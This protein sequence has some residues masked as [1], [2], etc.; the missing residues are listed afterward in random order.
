MITLAGYRIGTL[1]HE[2]NSTRLYDAV[3]TA[4][5]RPVLI[6]LLRPEQLT[7]ENR[8]AIRREKELT[9]RLDLEGVLR[10]LALET[11]DSGAALVL[12]HYGGLPLSHLSGRGTMKLEAVLAIARNVVDI[13]GGLHQRRIFHGN[14]SPESILVEPGTHKVKLTDLCLHPLFL[15]GQDADFC[16]SLFY[17]SPEQT[18]RMNR[19]VDFRTDFYSL[20]V[21]LYELLTGEVPFRSSD[22]LQLIHSHIA[23]EPKDPVAVNSTL[24]RPIADIVLKLLA[25]NAKDRYQSSYGLQKDLETCLSGL[26]A[27]GRI[28]DFTLAAADASPELTIPSRLYGRE[29][30]TSQLRAACERARLGSNELL[31][32]A[33][34]AGVGKTALIN[35]VRETVLE[36]GGLFLS[37]KYDQLKKNVPYSSII[38]A[39]KQ[40]IGRI[41]GENEDVLRRW[42]EK[43]LDAVSTNGQLIIDVIPDVKLIIGEQ[44]RVAPA[45]PAESLNRFNRVVQKFV[46]VFARPEHPLV[47]FLD[48]L[49]W[50]DPASLNLIR[51]LLTDSGLKHL[52][53]IGAFRS[54]EV[55]P[56]HPMQQLLD[57]NAG[58]GSVSRI[59]LE[60]LTEDQT[61]A[62]I[63]DTL[64]CPPDRSAPLARIVQYKTGGNPFFVNQM[65]ILLHQEKLLAYDPEGGWRWDIEEIS[66]RDVAEDVVELLVGKIGRLAPGTRE[67]LTLASC[68]GNRF[69]LAT[70]AIV[71]NRSED[72]ILQELI[73]ALDE[74]MV[75]AAEDRFLFFHDRIQEAAYSLLSADEKATVH[76]RIG[77]LI[78]ASTAAEHLQARVFYI[79]DQLNAGSICMADPSERLRLAELNF[80][81]GRK[82]KKSTAYASAEKYL[83]EGIALLPADVWQKRYDLAI[84][85]HKE[86]A[87]CASL[88]GDMERADLLFS[89]IELNASTDLDRAWP[90]AVRVPLYQGRGMPREAFRFGVNALRILGYDMPENP[91]K[92]DLAAELLKTLWH[93]KLYPARHF[94]DLPVLTDPKRNAIMDIFA[95]MAASAYF[96]SRDLL[97]LIMLKTFSFS[98]RYGNAPSSPAAYGLYGM[99]LGSILGNYERGHD[100]G[101]MGLALADKFNDPVSRAMADFTHA[102]FIAHWKEPLAKCLTL[103]VQGYTA[104]LESGNI[105]YAGY[106]AG[107]HTAFMTFKGD[108]LDDL[109]EQCRTYLEVLKK[110]GGEDMILGI[111]T[112]LSSAEELA[113][114]PAGTRIDDDQLIRTLTEGKKF[115]ALCLHYTFRLPV[116][117]LFGRYK[118]GEQFADDLDRKST[119]ILGLYHSAS[120]TFYQALI[121]AARCDGVERTRQKTY[122]RVLARN[123]KRLK[124]WTALC[125]A[126]FANKYLLVAAEHARLKGR[127]AE[128][129]DLYDRSIA[130]ALDN[131]F[132]HEAGIANELAGQFHLVHDRARIARSYLEEAL[133]CYRVW[134]AAAKVDQLERKYATVFQ[135]LPQSGSSGPEVLPAGA[136]PAQA[137]QALDLSTVLKLS[138]AISREISLDR[139]LPDLMR[140]V[141]E[142]AGARRGYLLLER[143]GK[144]LLEARGEADTGEFGLLPSTPYEG[145]GVLAESIVNYTARTREAVV[146]NNAVQEGMFTHDPIVRM[147]PVLSILCA[148]IMSKGRLTG[149]L[150]LENDLVSHAFT[151]ERLDIMAA[152]SSQIAISLENA[153]LYD[154]ARQAKESLEESEQKFRA[155]ADT[156]RSGIVIYR[157]ERFLYVNPAVERITGYTRAEIASMTFSDVIHRDFLPLVRQRAADRIAGRSVPAQYEYK[158]VRKSGEERWILSTAGR[159]L[160]GR[161]LALIATMLDVTEQKIAEEER[162]RLFEQNERQY[163][164]RIEEEL[165]HQREKE[166]ILMDIHDGIGGII[167]NISLLTELAQKAA[168]PRDA[169]KWLATISRL[170]RE[171]NL[172]IH[173]LMFSLDGREHTWRS[174]A[175]ELRSHGERLLSSHTIAFTMNANIEDAMGRPPALL[176][177]HL[178]R[179][180]RE[181]LNNVIKHAR[182]TEVT[183]NLRITA[184]E[185]VLAI[186]DNG[187]GFDPDAVTG[188]GRGVGNM[189]ARA[190]E[191]GGSVSF[192]TGA[193]TLITLTIPFSGAMDGNRSAQ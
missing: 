107:L 96:I 146:L 14:I 152:L 188:K 88:S 172:E 5:E 11:S 145:S 110:T 38:F 66:R 37:G 169:D 58:G 132:V 42:K 164:E 109:R 191:I 51:L 127:I 40:M 122:L 185:L 121:A 162:L 147:R 166:N 155:V 25:K 119:F 4:D 91:G 55:L 106:C 157:D 187:R 108:R 114:V 56:G 103:I 171:G 192:T 32:V 174:L 67:V 167:T 79:A 12:E 141:I 82:A 138:Q 150:Y 139:L 78:L 24:P 168:Q 126:N 48:D 15:G 68:I 117:Y 61:N 182:A 154:E 10:V 45:G 31:L 17:V 90:S 83:A 52:L 27:H 23:R 30:E 8:E 9:A 128:A 125:P 26:T 71:Q 173:S 159:I 16:R 65:L 39:F 46:G 6:K 85:L 161:D 93:A 59:D 176:F 36:Q 86:S 120:Y 179:I 177:L 186:R 158:I 180:Y 47:L 97:S 184:E 151:P 100:F 89:V 115:F 95:N 13:L 175:A 87:E 76:Y 22:P 33:G 84:G 137:S 92:L 77:T 140:T 149:I 3:R 21:T 20:G 53:I 190:A 181:A 193:G 7:A 64:R 160:Y 73:P 57:E 75:V 49:Q 142:N 50:I 183:V 153:R 148:P 60:S 156:V 178:F 170:A 189:K 99:L 34:G 144:M 35:G 81:A 43:L 143:D 124:Q 112:I 113:E 74:G 80:M 18:G 116:L 123:E 131:R 163:R 165:R 2:G 69:D 118:Q 28:E 111:T 94:L 1:L 130:A 104:A 136:A 29:R 129:Q 101:T 134:G 54:N 62:L 98:A 135:R 70:L 105:V 63:R 44:P 102:G 19:A 41:L 72:R 133:L